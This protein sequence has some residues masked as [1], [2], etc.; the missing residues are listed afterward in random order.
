MSS[1]AGGRRDHRVLL[2]QD[3]AELP[4]GAVAAVAVPGH[5]ELVAV[6]LLP[7]GAGL[8]RGVSTVLGT[9]PRPRSPPGQQLLARPRRPSLQVQQAELGDVLGRARAGR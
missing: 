9:S 2:G 6:A 8:G 5:P 1:V 3:H 7:V 4:E